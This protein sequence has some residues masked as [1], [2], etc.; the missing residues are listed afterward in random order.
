MKRITGLEAVVYRMSAKAWRTRP[1]TQQ[2]AEAGKTEEDIP[3]WTAEQDRKVQLILDSL[4]G[5]PGLTLSVNPDPNSCPFSRARLTPDPEVTGHTAE[6]LAA[7]LAEG[8]PAVVAR[9]HHADEGYIDLDAIEMTDQEIQ[10]SCD[11]VRRIL[12]Q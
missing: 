9:A 5:I 11:K 3:A 12:A 1:L 10:F 4:S 8:D 6:S 7:A 2:E